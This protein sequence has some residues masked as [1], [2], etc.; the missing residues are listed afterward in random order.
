VSGVK[1]ED[2]VLRER[3]SR[4]R[5]GRFAAALAMSSRQ[6]T[7]DGFVRVQFPCRALSISLKLT[8]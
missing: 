3:S 7:S 2:G 4:R 6:R 1:C 5:I 8:A